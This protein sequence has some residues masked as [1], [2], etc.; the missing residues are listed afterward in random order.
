M[1][2]HDGDDRFALLARL[3]RQHANALQASESLSWSRCLLS[4]VAYALFLSDVLR[5]GV[6]SGHGN[7]TAVVE[8]GVYMT[9]GP[10]DY[11]IVHLTSANASLPSGARRFWPYKYDTTSLGMRAIALVLQLPTWSSCLHYASS[12]DETNGLPGVIVFRML[13][14]LIDRVAHHSNS[15]RPRVRSGR[16]A[17]SLTLRIEHAFRD[18]LNEA[19]LP[20]IFYRTLRRTT[21]ASYFSTARLRSQRPLCDGRATHPFACADAFT[22]FGRLCVVPKPCTSRI[23]R[24]HEHISRRLALLQRAYP[25]AALELV[26]VDSI[27]DFSRPGVVAHG[28]RDFDTVAFV[29]VRRCIGNSS[30]NCSTIAVDEYRYEGMML[31]TGGTEWLPI[32]ALL[33]STGQ[34]HA[35][36]RVT[37]LVVGIVAVKRHTASSSVRARIQDIVRTF[38][39]I[40][41]H[42]VIYGSVAPIACY[43]A[44]HLLDSSMVYEQVRADFNALLGTFRFDFAAFI[45]LAT[46]SMRTVWLVALGCHVL[47]WLSTQRSWSRDLGVAGVSDLFIAFVSCFTVFAHLRIPN[48]RDCRVLQV[49]RIVSSQRLRDVNA[50]TF[51]SSRGTVNEIFLGATSDYQFIALGITAVAALTAITLIINTKRG[52]RYQLAVAAHTRVPYS[53]QWLWP[54]NALVVNW[55]DSITQSS[56]ATRRSTGTWL[57]RSTPS[58]GPRKQSS[59]LIFS[60]ELLSTQERDTHDRL[61]EFEYRSR[62][63]TAFISMLNLTVMSDPLVFWRLRRRVGSR[64]VALYRSQDSGKLWLLPL[65]SN[66]MLL[67][68]PI[69][70]DRLLRL[71]IFTTDELSWMDLLLCG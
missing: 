18:R 57:A 14:E 31:A 63:A 34:L 1:S 3:R 49:H 19:I 59:V 43:V 68:A 70:C 69:E 67:D 13:D 39:L 64:L 22:N 45:R 7:A 53:C 15:M 30:V 29:R 5:T 47:T 11:P 71:A 26:I 51:D 41:S 52:R 36:L 61:L 65:Q 8:P 50:H 35:W 9:F 40:P 6:G 32:I 12:C 38:L 54:S 48:W 33:R 56:P 4:V 23:G 46:V 60:V 25:D 27:Q 10:Y 16:D 62:R 17:T 21:Q 24:I 42:V 28:R 66:A 37:S 58:E 20:S 44:A 55:V 2:L